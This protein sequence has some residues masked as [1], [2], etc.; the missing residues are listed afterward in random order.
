MRVPSLKGATK[1]K[2]GHPSQ[3]P[4]ALIAQLLRASS[5]EGDLVVDP[6]LGSGSTAETAEVNRRKWLGVE[7]NPEYVQM[8]KRRIET[9]NAQRRD[10]PAKYRAA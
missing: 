10:C 6:F 5:R 2:V 8:A 4:V 3:K 7:Q 9:G 1:E